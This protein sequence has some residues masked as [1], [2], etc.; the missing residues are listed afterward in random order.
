MTLTRMTLTRTRTFG[1]G[2]MDLRFPRASLPQDQP[3]PTGAHF[4]TESTVKGI[5]NDTVS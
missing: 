3:F 2:R 5:G 4:L 1:A